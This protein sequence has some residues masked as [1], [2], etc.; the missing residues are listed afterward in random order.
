M[1]ADALMIA[2]S[3]RCGAAQLRAVVASALATLC[4]L[5]TVGA[6]AQDD[7]GLPLGA[8]S[9]GAAYRRVVA[10]DTQSGL[11]SAS[12]ESQ[13]NFREAVEPSNS[14]CSEGT[15]QFC[16]D[17]ANAQ[18]EFKPLKGLL[19]DI[20]R[21]TPHNVYVRRNKVTVAYTFK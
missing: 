3:P 2:V 15:R 17:L 5:F 9:A 4:A 14:R 11:K 21:L 16:S 18:F 19:P 1:F 10:A 13:R 20:P 12:V 7:G 6:A 8:Q